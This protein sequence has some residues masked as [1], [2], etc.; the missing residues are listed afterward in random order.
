M[1]LYPQAISSLKNPGKEHFENYLIQ[2]W[3]IQKFVSLQ[4]IMRWVYIL[5]ADSSTVVTRNLIEHQGCYFHI[6][7]ITRAY[8]KCWYDDNDPLAVSLDLMTMAVYMYCIYVLIDFNFFSLYLFLGILSWS[9]QIESPYLLPCFLNRLRHFGYPLFPVYYRCL[10][11]LWL[12]LTYLPPLLNFV[13]CYSNQVDPVGVH[14]SIPTLRADCVCHIAS[15]AALGSLKP[16]YRL[17]YL[18]LILFF[19]PQTVDKVLCFLISIC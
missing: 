19:F 4:N 8:F 6:R 13:F 5:H 2:T 18:S 10:C 12:P 14:V 7:L 9:L 3:E 15:S 11:W 16:T 1:L 17:I